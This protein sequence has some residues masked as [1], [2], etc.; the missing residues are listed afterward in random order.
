MCC[1]YANGMLTHDFGVYEFES[2]WSV[3]TA[4]DSEVINL[5]PSFPL[6]YATLRENIPRFLCCSTFHRV[7]CRMLGIQKKFRPLKADLTFCCKRIGIFTTL[8]V[9]LH[10]NGLI[11]IRM[12][13]Y[14]VHVS[15]NYRPEH[16]KSAASASNFP[17]LCRS[18]PAGERK[19]SL[20]TWSC[21]IGFQDGSTHEYPRSKL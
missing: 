13:E 6:I 4:S 12:F 21:L 18:F 5:T 8:N 10:N 9:K 15:L 17:E 3:A 19:R 7:F 20:I 14:D 11:T 16:Q 2:R 1:G